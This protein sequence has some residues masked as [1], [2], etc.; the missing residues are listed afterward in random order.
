ML[1]LRRLSA[2][3][4]ASIC[5]VPS[6]KDDAS[7]QPSGTESDASSSDGS[8]TDRPGT[9]TDAG[10]GTTTT[11]TD[12][13]TSSS[14]TTAELTSS[15]DSSSGGPERGPSPASGIAIPEIEANQGVA[16][17]I[18]SDGASVPGEDRTGPL[19]SDRVTAIR[20][21]WVVDGDWEAREIEAVLTLSQAD[22]TEETIIDRKLVDGEASLG[23]LNRTFVWGLM[24]EQV[25][26]GASIHV[27]LFEVDESFADPE[28]TTP[29]R[30]PLGEDD[31]PIGFESSDQV[32]RVV[33]VPFNYDNGVCVAEPDV[34]EETIQ[35]YHDLIFQMNPVDEVEIVMHAPVDWNQQLNTF[36]EL[37]TFMSD[38]RFQESADP[39]VYYYGVIN[40]CVNDVDGFGGLAHGI[41]SNPADMGVAYQRVASGLALASAQQ[42]SA[43]LFVHEIGHTQGRYHVACSGEEAGPDP[44]YPIVG[45]DVGAWGFGVIDFGLRHPTVAK[46]IMTYCEPLWISP[47]GWNHTYPV[48]ATLSSWDDQDQRAPEYETS[49]LVGTITDH[50]EF[51]QTVP[52]SKPGV[53]DGTGPV[54]EVEYRGRTKFRV[55]ASVS[56]LPDTGDLRVVAELPRK[57]DRPKRIT[58]IDGGVRRPVDMA[59]LRQAHLSR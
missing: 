39:E 44:S 32:L 21:P 57:L 46:D 48:I 38:L 55:D 17:A 3:L 30:F 9:T 15:S 6:C 1:E 29:P 2:C 45:G 56:V 18:G 20:A 24:P 26:P 12:E 40:A 11:T 47:F 41:P 23:N 53:S 43:D 35:L 16:T 51:W 14:S 59:K 19:I 54:V 49:L 4:F 5:L 52:G 13:S 31:A 37:N 42:F 50:G 22:G 33:I 7:E 34:S 36:A 25:V 8:T 58:R 10:T 27:E 28:V